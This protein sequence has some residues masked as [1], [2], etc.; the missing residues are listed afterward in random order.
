MEL[1]AG[2]YILSRSPT[3]SM[4]MTISMADGRHVG[5]VLTQPVDSER[6]NQQPQLDFERV[7]HAMY[8]TQITFGYGEVCGISAA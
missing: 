6:Q 7:G 8:L 3:D 1:P 2:D 5:L 4:L